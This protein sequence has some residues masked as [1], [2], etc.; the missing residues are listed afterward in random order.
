MVVPNR[1]LTEIGMYLKQAV[2]QKFEHLVENVYLSD[3]KCQNLL[4]E[5]S[6]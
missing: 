5:M 6:T 2:P 3:W 4:A 1:E